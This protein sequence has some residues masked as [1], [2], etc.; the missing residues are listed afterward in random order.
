MGLLG[1]TMP[2]ILQA[3]ALEESRKVAPKAKNV[4]FLFQFGG[5]SHVDMFDMKPDAPSEYRSPHGQRRTSCPDIEINERLPELARLMDEVTVIR[6]VHHKMKNHNSAAYYALS[7]HAPAT[8]D[9]RLRDT[10]DLYPAYGSVV[11]HLAPSRDTALPTFVSYPHHIGDGSRTPGQFASFL[12]KRHDPLFI[13]RDPNKEDFKIPELSLPEGLTLDR[14]Q[15]RRGLQQIIDQQAH[16]LDHAAE[17]QGLDDY[18]TKALSMLHSP[19]VRKAFDLSQESSAL[20]DRYGRTTYGQGCLLARRL[21]EHGVKFSTVYFSR[22]IGGR[23]KTD[24]G[25]DTHGFDNTRMFPIIEDYHLP[26]TDQTLPTLL[27]DLKMRGLLD[28]TLVIWMGEFGRTPKIN[29]NASRDHWPQCYSVLLAG[30]GVKRGYIYGASDKLGEHPTED[31]VTPEDLAATIYQLIGI[32]PNA[33]I[34]DTQDRPLPIS[35][36]KPIWDVIA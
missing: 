11:D 6:S 17:A 1:M 32:D 22:S 24:G 26:I 33:M 36:G 27:T 14:L 5:P 29:K 12:G 19:K 10:I 8:D 31:P 9:Q 28:E 2:K 18:Y 16:L 34:I 20:R 7:G 30:G 13:P 3:R 23:S 15:S 25:W 21:V 4:I 35:S